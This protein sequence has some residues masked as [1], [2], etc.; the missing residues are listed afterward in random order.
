VRAARALR[1]LP[2]V[3]A[4][5]R[6]GELSFAKVRALT[7]VAT[8]EN[9]A[10]LLAVART[11]TAAQVERIVRA[12]RRVDRLEEQQAE[13]GRHDSRHLSIHVDED[14]MYIVRGRLDPEAGALLEKALEVAGDVLFGRRANSSKL[15]STRADHAARADSA[16]R[17]A[18]AS[19]SPSVDAAQRRADALALVAERALTRAQA[20]DAAASRG[21]PFEVVIHVDADGLRRE[22]AT[23]QAVIAGGVRVSAETSRRLACDAGRVIMMSDANG[24]TI[25]V[26]RRT[27]TVPAPIRRALEHRD[28]TCRFPGCDVRWCDAHHIIHWADGG[29][30]GLANLVLLCRRH[31]RAVHE[32]GFRIARDAAGDLRFHY[33]DGRVIPA[34]PPAPELRAD[35]PALHAAQNI[36]VDGDALVSFWT[37]QSLDVH[38]AIATLR[39]R[40]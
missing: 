37:G 23:G 38:H 35:L 11:G 18:A 5:M 12:W 24:D 13:A 20:Q 26:G 6:C 14:G 25:D 7:R 1:T 40:E 36:V 39:P 34:V 27:R 30:T 29:T 8:V 19:P 33:P 17:P 9:E 2:H 3:S 15:R 28:R 16:G 10:E 22:A 32:E 31:H 4:A 21:Q